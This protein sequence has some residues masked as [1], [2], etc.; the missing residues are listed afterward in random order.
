[1]PERIAS[2]R[3]Y[4]RDA[5]AEF[6]W[7]EYSVRDTDAFERFLEEHA[8]RHD[9][10][11]HMVQRDAGGVTFQLPDHSVEPVWI[12]KVSVADDG[13]VTSTYVAS[14]TGT[15]SPDGDFDSFL[16]DREERHRR[17]V[18]GHMDALVAR[19]NKA[20]EMAGVLEDLAEYEV[21]DAVWD[22]L[23]EGPVVDGA[24]LRERVRR[25]H[26]NEK[27]DEIGKEMEDDLF[28]R[29]GEA[30]YGDALYDRV[31]A[32]VAGMD[33]YTF[34]EA[35]KL[36]FE[37]CTDGREMRDYYSTGKN[38]RREEMEHIYAAALDVVEDRLDHC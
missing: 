22:E 17:L 33:D 4:R 24:V 26:G 27:L 30:E 3:R 23:Q 32:Q 18:E 21:L 6:R 13:T 16:E 12:S 10:P 38:V 36:D 1:M 2:K 9:H 14:V 7:D 5:R 20:V 11:G 8:E 29:F 19:S 35:P 28:D 15:D 34:S 37:I 31:V 25:E